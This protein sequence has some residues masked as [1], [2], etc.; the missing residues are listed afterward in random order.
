MEV[1]IMWSLK[2]LNYL[3][4]HPKMLEHVMIPHLSFNINYGDC[5]GKANVHYKM[6]FYWHLSVKH[7]IPYFPVK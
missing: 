3:Q 7:K 1:P 2:M 6:F 4:K 5:L